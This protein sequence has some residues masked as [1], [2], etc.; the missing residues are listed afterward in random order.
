MDPSP[1]TSILKKKKGKSEHRLT[2]THTHTHTG[3]GHVKK[4]T[5][6]KNA[7]ATSQG[8]PRVARNH[9]RIRERLVINFPLE[10]SVR[11]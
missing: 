5:E 11:V 10:P 7:A 2:H 1:K 9:Q 4:D 6:T 8:M 3:E